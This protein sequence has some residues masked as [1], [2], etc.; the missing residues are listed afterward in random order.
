VTQEKGGRTHGARPHCPADLNRAHL[1]QEERRHSIA[2]PSKLDVVQELGEG[3]LVA[4][5]RDGIGEPSPLHL[6]C[7]NRCQLGPARQLLRPSRV[8]RLAA[9]V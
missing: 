7:A 2:F 1:V 5:C 8:E 3:R 6:V 9:R 4:L